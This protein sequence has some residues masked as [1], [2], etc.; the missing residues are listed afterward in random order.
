MAEAQPPPVILHP[1]SQDQL[2]NNGAGH[3][4]QG[5]PAIQPIE[6]PPQPPVNNNNNHPPQ[7]E[8]KLPETRH[9]GH[10]DRRSGT[11]AEDRHTVTPRR[12]PNPPVLQP[13]G[14]VETSASVVSVLLLRWQNMGRPQYSN[15]KHMYHLHKSIV[16]CNTNSNRTHIYM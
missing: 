16:L 11:R 7:S 1:H 6:P 5:G 15:G 3:Y 10:T 12:P 13:F 9:T 14:N 8:P 4:S 2:T